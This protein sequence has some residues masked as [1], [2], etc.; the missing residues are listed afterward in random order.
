M[1]CRCSPFLQP[2]LFLHFVFSWFCFFLGSSL[3]GSS[4]NKGTG[5]FGSGQQTSGSLFG[6]KTTTTTPGFTGQINKLALWTPEIFIINSPG[7]FSLFSLEIIYENLR[8]DPLADFLFSLIYLLYK[9]LMSLREISFWI[10][11][12]VLRIFSVIMNHINIFLLIRKYM[13]IS[14]HSNAW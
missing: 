3:F 5:L 10:H 9:L 12:D 4:A 6:Q 13:Y 7:C 14:F 11:L 2:C 1:Y 8:L